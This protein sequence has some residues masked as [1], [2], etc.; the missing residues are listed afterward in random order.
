VLYRKLSTGYSAGHHVSPEHDYKIH[1]HMPLSHYYFSGIGGSGMS[2]LA[3]V[4]CA[5]GYRVSGSDRTF[6]SGG[7]RQLFRK[8]QAQGIRLVPQDAASLGADI[9]FLIVSS[10]IEALSSERTQARRLGIPVLHRAELLARLF[11]PAEGIGIA[12]T[13]GKSTVTG[14]L[15]SIFD[16]DRRKATVINGG[17]ISRYI[18]GTLPGN[19]RPGT[20]PWCLAELDESDGSIVNF[21]A[22][23]GLITNISQDHK[24]LSEL[25]KLFQR[26][27]DQSRGPLVLNADC[28]E[29]A[30][31]RAPGAVWF[32][33][34]HA[35]HY[36]AVNIS[37]L[38]DGMRFSINNMNYSI[39]VPGRHNV[40]NAA[41]AVAL[42][43]ELG[44]HPK[45]CQRGLQR[46]KGIQRRLSRIALVE[47][48]SIWDDFAH[49]PDKLRAS[50][51]ALR[52]LS[53]RML[54]V[55]QPHGFGPTRFMRDELA[56]AL[57]AGMRRSDVLIGLPIFDAGGT[58][59]RSITTADLLDRVQ[60]P[61]CLVAVDRK[62]ALQEILSR[63]RTGDAVAIMGARDD[64]LSAFA[65]SIARALRRCT[66]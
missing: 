1:Q 56:R 13:S 64:S 19:A 11:N 47:G 12:G 34:E 7:N 25:R 4:L 51:A 30:Q 33:I 52:P 44:I 62:E 61:R 41:A 28:P 27:I 66:K 10:A 49:N 21:C 2:A 42:S 46:F 63:A 37:A 53:K 57:S 20:G 38:P 9:D 29:S 24:T 54:I 32:G 65:R 60:G 16:A 6:D 23:A 22:A 55:F 40:A 18:T 35:A 39:R 36:R 45:V 43:S 59:D 26:F 5:Q 48:V 58:A 8:L 50:L 31:L 17:C 14:M 15:A 3:Q